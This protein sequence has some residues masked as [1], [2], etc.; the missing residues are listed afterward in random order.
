MQ[1][2]T[3]I[4]K[5]AGLVLVFSPYSPGL[6]FLFHCTC[7][8]RFQMESYS[9][10]CHVLSCTFMQ[11]IIPSIQACRRDWK[12]SNFQRRSLFPHDLGVAVSWHDEWY[13]LTFLPFHTFHIDTSHRNPCGPT[14]NISIEIYMFAY[15]YVCKHTQRYRCHN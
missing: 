13:T 7:P 6:L 10:P 1:Y 15:M 9:H 3:G 8:L 12:M 11:L 2:R 5:K 14:T 4:D